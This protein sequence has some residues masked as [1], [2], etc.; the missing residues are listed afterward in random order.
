[1]LL[2]PSGDA[3]GV[4]LHP[5]VFAVLLGRGKLE[6]VSSKLDSWRQTVPNSGPIQA[7]SNG[8]RPIQPDSARLGADSAQF[9]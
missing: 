3:V 4:E 5:W 7:D 6:M 1:M 9:R 8:T 2:E